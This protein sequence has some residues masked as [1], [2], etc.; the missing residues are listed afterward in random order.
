MQYSVVF[1]VA[2]A[3]YSAGVHNPL[4]DILNDF[5]ERGGRI[6]ILTSIMNNFNNPDHL[7][8]LKKL[9]P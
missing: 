1:N 9:A 5:T 8:L 7:A 4:I 6:H 2:T 3:F